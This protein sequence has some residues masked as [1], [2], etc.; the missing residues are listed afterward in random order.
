M[1]KPNS[2][3]KLDI[4]KTFT[5]IHTL[6]LP[7]SRRWQ[8]RIYKFSCSRKRLARISSTHYVSRCLIF[9]RPWAN[10]SFHILFCLS[11]R[12]RS[13]WPR[14]KGWRRRSWRRAISIERWFYGFRIKTYL[15]W[16]G[17]ERVSS[18]M[19]WYTHYDQN[20]RKIQLPWTPLYTVTLKHKW[21]GMSG[22]RL[23]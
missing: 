14:R 13:A 21:P 3:C 10:F 6:L 19:N 12:R 4:S 1:I 5:T 15:V 7:L 9:K 16:W 11:T 23:K 22:M 2:V 20:A 18:L 8:A 17:G